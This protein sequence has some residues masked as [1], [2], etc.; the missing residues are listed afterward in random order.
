MEAFLVSTGV[1]ALAE[2][3][4]KLAHRI[5]LRLTRAVAAAIFAALGV[6]VALAAP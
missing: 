4:D 3:G 1:V 2:M 5:A 6:V